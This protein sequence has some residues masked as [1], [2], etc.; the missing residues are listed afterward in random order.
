MGGSYSFKLFKRKTIDYEY[1]EQHYEY[2]PGFWGLFSPPE[3]KE[4]IK[5][6]DRYET[7]EEFLQRATD[8]VNTNGVQ[9]VS[10]QP[11][12]Y[13]Y[14]FHTEKRYIDKPEW[15][16]FYRTE[17]HPTFTQIHVFY[18]H[19]D[20]IIED[21][22]EVIEDNNEVIENNNKK[23]ES[24]DED[25]NEDEEENEDESD[26]DSSDESYETETSDDSYESESSEN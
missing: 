11:A 7:D 26:D 1:K 20:E 4:Y 3:L 25:N 15:H 8:W 24:E 19:D 18:Y 22:N 21:N 2:K 5:Y 16:E 14:R 9:V 10:L 23:E 13:I 17:L 6:A 12:N